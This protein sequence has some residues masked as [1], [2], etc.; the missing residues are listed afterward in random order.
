MQKDYFG[1]NLKKLLQKSRPA[2]YRPEFKEALFSRMTQELKHNTK[3]TPKWQWNIFGNLLPPV[4]FRLFLEAAAVP[5]IIMLVGIS[6]LIN[7][8][9]NL[10]VED[11]KIIIFQSADNRDYIMGNGQNAINDIAH[12]SS[13]HGSCQIHPDIQAEGSQQNLLQLPATNNS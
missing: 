5:M 2:A 3:V 13:S 11:G 8:R 7:S 4:G 12:A 9:T 1:I 10:P 6:Y